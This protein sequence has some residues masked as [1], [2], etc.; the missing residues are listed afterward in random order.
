MN[1]IRI[2]FLLVALF[3][4]L[5]HASAQE[6]SGSGLKCHQPGSAFLKNDNPDCFL[7]TKGEA[8]IA[9]RK[10]CWDDAG[11][12]YRAAKLCRDANQDDRTAMNE[13]VEACRK[14]AEDELQTEKEKAIRQARHAIASN[15]ANDAQELLRQDVRTTA[16]RLAN[17]AN[18]YI[19]PAD[20][21][22]A[23][24]QQAIL[25]AWQ[26]PVLAPDGQLLRPFAY[27]LMQNMGD[28]VEIRFAQRAG[29]LSLFGFSASKSEFYEW[30]APEFVMKGSWSI[31]TTMRHFDTSPDGQLALFYSDRSYLLVKDQQKVFQINVAATGKYC[32]SASGDYFFYYDP[33]EQ[34]IMALSLIDLFTTSKEK[35]KK[36]TSTTP[37]FERVVSIQSAPKAIA[38]KGAHLW[39]VYGDSLAILESQAS[40]SNLKVWSVFQ[41]MALDFP[42]NAT[43][44]P[45]TPT[46]I[47]ISATDPVIHKVA[48]QSFMGLRVL[49]GNDGSYYTESAGV[50]AGVILSNDHKVWLQNDISGTNNYY[51]LNEKGKINTIHT[52]QYYGASA[53]SATIGRENVSSDQADWLAVALPTGSLEVWRLKAF[54][55][56]KDVLPFSKGG[57]MVSSPNGRILANAVNGQPLEII[58]DEGI[59][60][61]GARVPFVAESFGPIAL[62]V[63]N[64]GWVVC[65]SVPNDTILLTN[66]KQSWYFQSITYASNPEFEFSKNGDYLAMVV[67]YDSVAV[68]S[69]KGE[70]ALV[71]GR[72]FDAE[73]D[74]VAFVPG[75]DA[76]VV[77][78]GARGGEPPTSITIPR[79]WRFLAK[80]TNLAS[81]RL[82]RFYASEIVPRYDGQVIYF[83]DGM[84]IKGFGLDDLTDEKVLI[85][86][87]QNAYISTFACHPTK[88]V[89]AVALNNGKVV[90]RDADTGKKLYQIEVQSKVNSAT[91]NITHIAFS[92]DGKML[93]VIVD[94]NELLRFDLDLDLIQKR[95]HLEGGYLS[96]FTPEQIGGWELDKA[97]EYDNNFEQLATSGDL[98]L[99]RAFFEFYSR[100]AQT[101][102]RI[103]DV[104][105]NC[106]HAAD[107]YRLLDEE[108]QEVQYY[109]ILNMYEDYLWKL[110]QRNQIS[111]A[112]TV[113]GTL[114]KNAA[115]RTSLPVLR[116]AGHL[117]LLKNDLKNALKN[118]IEWQIVAKEDD[119]NG[120]ISEANKLF[121]ELIQLNDYGYLTPEQRGAVCSLFAVELSQ[122]EAFC[123]GLDNIPSLKTILANPVVL[124]RWNIY[125]VLQAAIFDMYGVSFANQR[126]SL[127]AALRDA[128][129]LATLDAAEGKVQTEAVLLA[130]ADLS[131]READFEDGSKRAMQLYAEGIEYLGGNSRWTTANEQFRLDYLAGLYLS[132]GKIYLYNDVSK[133]LDDFDKG[134]EV[135]FKAQKILE[136]QGLPTV[137]F[138]DRITGQL[139]VKKGMALLMLDRPDD[140]EQAFTQASGLLRGG[141]NN[142][143][144]G[145]T[146]LIRKE[147]ETIFLEYGGLNNLPIASKAIAEM[148]QLAYQFEADQERF[149]QIK[150]S[151]GRLTQV[152]PQVSPEVDSVDL[153]YTVS[154]NMTSYFRFLHRYD[155][156]LQW[157]N[158]ALAIV[159]EN[160]DTTKYRT[161]NLYE[162]YNRLTDATLSVAYYTIF[163]H[164]KVAVEL[165]KVAAL[166]DEAIRVHEYNYTRSGYLLYTNAGHIALLRGDQK[167]ALAYYQ[168]FLTTGGDNQTSVEDVLFKDWRDMEQAGIIL[169]GLSTM[170]KELFG[171]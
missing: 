58:Q 88:P 170:K 116:T 71:A 119:W 35:G 72:R 69:L 37:R 60:I 33:S 1:T 157:S 20:E 124:L 82:E 6:S 147:Y 4:V 104:K 5:F 132:R 67:D 153:E 3:W 167:K 68:L 57:N 164:P 166:S 24:C 160:M 38:Q 126:S 56:T 22:N 87:L 117:A 138:S 10:G 21:D 48:F 29:G 79:I 118:Y 94:Y 133:A 16:Y 52:N 165:D 110:V 90:F 135:A 140:A 106:E 134:L 46:T 105:S 99:I 44:L 50:K 142:M 161:K 150:S 70:P 40:K 129:Q 111:Q 30:R 49:I 144:F 123:G 146:A 14:A 145:H 155:D 53:Q 159:R 63:S 97:L 32:F 96:A 121:N 151:I 54:D 148:Y 91:R 41:K 136:E 7:L 62:A 92:Q 130:L 2:N 169:D 39:V 43:L 143:Y 128:R 78:R 102:N 75:A 8:D 139:L 158:H 101:S 114:K 108:S 131:H 120:G 100:Q 18:E 13:R 86:Q 34:K 23:D 163:Q 51:L 15:R 27:E 103:D 64:S 113:L 76:L 127:N 25:D 98:P 141:L 66:G 154:Y 152:L 65:T 84:V 28:S 61:K 125:S 26:A 83:S 31:D 77:Q 171:K 168:K 55:S 95:L 81:F 73:V 156:A 112:E 17:F 59:M 74:K 93:L 36:S 162:W 42:Q 115:F 80:E 19:A 9:F 149:N 45:G 47:R 137:D 89:L 122:D 12:L 109:T 107:L 85:R 11:K